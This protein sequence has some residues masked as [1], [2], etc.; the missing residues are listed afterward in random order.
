[1][2]DRS[3]GLRSA[4]RT[5][6]EGRR[7]E[8][9][10]RR[11]VAAHSIGPAVHGETLEKTEGNGRRS[12]TGGRGRGRRGG[13]AANSRWRERDGAGRFRHDSTR[14]AWPRPG[15]VPACGRRDPPVSVGL[16]CHLSACARRSRSGRNSWLTSAAVPAS[17]ITGRPRG[18]PRREAPWSWSP[19][20]RRAP[21]RTDRRRFA[22][23]HSAGPARQCRRVR[24]RPWPGLMVTTQ[25]PTESTPRKKPTEGRTVAQ[26]DAD[27]GPGCA[28]PALPP[29]A[30]CPPARPTW[31]H[32]SVRTRSGA[33][34]GRRPCTA[35]M[36]GREHQTSTWPRRHRGRGSRRWRLIR[37]LGRAERF[38]RRV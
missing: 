28:R 19:A 24:S 16:S 2:L 36:R 35:A 29:D 12:R 9:G 13:R 30:P 32:E 27:L 20:G 8:A 10:G 33:R 38:A 26:N 11:A 5:M 25:P 17:A 18:G 3:S 37:H 21:A 4:S 31:D 23:Q 6:R 1:M 15:L 14:S 7:D 34:R 22:G